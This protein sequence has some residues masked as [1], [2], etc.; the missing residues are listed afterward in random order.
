MTQILPPLVLTL[1]APGIPVSPIQPTYYFSSVTGNDANPGT[2]GSP[3][4]TWTEFLNRIGVLRGIMPFLNIRVDCYILDDLAVTDELYIPQF[5]RGP[6]GEFHV[7]GVPKTVRT[8]TLTAVTP[9]NPSTN[10]ADEFQD[11][12]FDWTPYLGLYLISVDV[13]DAVNGPVEAIPLKQLTAPA[14]VRTNIA[15]QQIANDYYNPIARSPAPGSTYRI[16]QLPKV[17]TF[18]MAPTNQFGVEETTANPP[19]TINYLD[20]NQV[21]IA[22]GYMSASLGGSFRSC[23]F[24]YTLVYN[25]NGLGLDNCVFNGGAGFSSGFVAG[26]FTTFLN[27]SVTFQAANATMFGWFLQGSQIYG[28]QLGGIGFCIANHH[29]AFGLA[30]FD[31]ATPIQLGPDCE[32]VNESR[33]YGTGNTVCCIHVFNGG[34]CATFS[35]YTNVFF[36]ATGGG[37]GYSDFKVNGQTSLPAMDKTT[38]PWALTSTLRAC[39][40]AHLNTTVAAG[41]FQGNCFDP[42]DP[43]TAFTAG[44]S[45]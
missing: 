40:F 21:G 23:I 43:H 20:F 24:P 35:D 33:V 4:K 34:K 5:S 7:W 32:L 12:T 14:R 38:T 26:S 29:G 17:S 3:L 22:H 31:A 44:I 28:S 11:G 30:V 41:G 1:T 36:F 6:G 8:S 16:L 9:R 15:N 27:A 19:F 2:S 25:T 13:G 39:T 18:R 37:G 10:Q 45:L 42:G